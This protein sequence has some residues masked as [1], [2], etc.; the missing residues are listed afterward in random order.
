MGYIYVMTNES[1]ADNII[2]I[3]YTDDIERRQKEL[4]TTAVPVP[5][6]IYCTYETNM[7]NSDKIIH[8]RFSKFRVNGKREFFR[9]APEEVYK[10]L[11]LIAR[12]SGTTDKLRLYDNKE[13]TNKTESSQ[14][15]SEIPQNRCFA[16]RRYSIYRG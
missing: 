6:D 12:L 1:Y 9:L 16:G 14:Q 3:G 4:F 7:K 2:K 8:E 10:E 13:E 15:A 11:S 5:F